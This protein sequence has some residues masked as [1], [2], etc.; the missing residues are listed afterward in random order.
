MNIKHDV[1][2]EVFLKLRI[3]QWYN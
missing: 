1:N 3:W 2:L